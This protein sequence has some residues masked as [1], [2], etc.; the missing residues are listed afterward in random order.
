[1]E[2]L[3]GK[4]PANTTVTCLFQSFFVV[5]A[6]VSDMEMVQDRDEWSG[7]VR[8]PSSGTEF[9]IFGNTDNTLTFCRLYEYDII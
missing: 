8:T 2:S 5:K 1:M 4:L 9:K 7:S 6:F 3:L